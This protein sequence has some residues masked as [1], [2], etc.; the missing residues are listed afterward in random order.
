MLK[1]IRLSQRRNALLWRN[2]TMASGSKFM[3]LPLALF[4]DGTMRMAVFADM[5]A[6]LLAVLNGL[7]LQK[8]VDIRGV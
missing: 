6:S 7:R 2:I 4:V 5:V 8:G 1:A 3:F